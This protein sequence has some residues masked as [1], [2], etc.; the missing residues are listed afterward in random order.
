MKVTSH[1]WGE[2]SY[3]RHLRSPFLFLGLG[4]VQ[5]ALPSIVLGGCLQDYDL[6]IWK[7]VGPPVG[8]VYGYPPRADEET[9]IA[10]A[11]ARMEVRARVYNQAI[12]SVMVSKFTQGGEKLDDTIKWA[13]NELDA[14]L[15]A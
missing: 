6:D 2:R 4:S 14:T 12:N 11:P 5:I 1:H 15:R 10:G 13:E 8:T 7:T 9:S 3:R